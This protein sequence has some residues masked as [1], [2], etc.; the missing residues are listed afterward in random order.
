MKSKKILI[1]GRPGIGKTT[2]IKKTVH[3]L[4]EMGITSDGFYTEEIRENGARVGFRIIGL[5]G[6]EG[7]LAHVNFDT[8]LRVGRYFVDTGDLDKCIDGIKK[9]E[10]ETVIIDEIGKMEMFSEKFREFVDELLESDKVVIGT[11]GER[12][13]GRF[14]DRA[15]VIRIGIENRDKAADLILDLLSE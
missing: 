4:R 2:V 12:L 13:V 8:N 14:K 11:V 15:E 7:V 6:F 9:S 3:R 5:S 10:S 1:T